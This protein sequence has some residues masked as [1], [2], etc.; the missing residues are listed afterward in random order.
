MHAHLIAARTDEHLKNWEPPMFTTERC[1][2]CDLYWECRDALD[3]LPGDCNQWRPVLARA[4][5]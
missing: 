3:T 5:T 4:T 2:T 1:S